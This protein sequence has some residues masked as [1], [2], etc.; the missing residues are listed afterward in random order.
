MQE[1]AKYDILSLNVRGIRDQVKWRS[2]FQ[3]LK[4]HNSKIYFLQETYSQPEDEIIWKNEWGGEIFFSHGTKHS[5][6][7]CILLHPTV[8]KK[9]DYS[10]SDKVGRIVLI[11]CVLNSLKLSLVN[12]H[13]PNSQSEQLEFL[14]NLNNCLIDKSEIS[15]LIV[16]GDWNCTLSKMDKTGGTIWKPTNYRNLILTTM[17]AFDLVDIQRLRHPRLQKYSYE[18]KSVNLK[19]RIDFFLLAKNLTQYVK[20]SEIYPSIA[21]DH[22]AIYISLSWTNGLNFRIP[23]HFFVSSNPATAVPRWP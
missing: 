4:D 20:K 5:K 19:S 23:G 11:T 12:I 10:F 14:Q 17:D 21:P 18:S 8:Q 2:I 22:R 7:V 16:G 3:Y 13:A 9:I 1:K 6:V 15:T